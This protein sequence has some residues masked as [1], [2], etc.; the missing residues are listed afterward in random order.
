METESLTGIVQLDADSFRD[1]NWGDHKPLRSEDSDPRI[2]SIV[3]GM[4]ALA[5]SEGEDLDH[6]AALASINVGRSVTEMRG[7]SKLSDAELK[8]FVADEIRDF[9][10]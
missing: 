10:R 6:L 5:R 3:A 9:H 1:G 8:A 2:D 4:E 7:R